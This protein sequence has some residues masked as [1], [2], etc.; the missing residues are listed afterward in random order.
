MG[1]AITVTFQ[2][3]KILWFCVR[4]MKRIWIYQ[5]GSDYPYPIKTIK[6]ES[7]SLATIAKLEMPLKHTI[8]GNT[9]NSLSAVFTKRMKRS[10]WEA[11]PTTS[12]RGTNSY[13]WNSEYTKPIRLPRAR[14]VS[15]CRK[16]EYTEPIGTAGPR[17]S[18]YCWKTQ[19][20]HQT[21]RN[22][23]GNSF[24]CWKTWIH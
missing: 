6:F 4:W 8:Q 11:K 21:Y 15:Y 1:E 5:W 2:E 14:R 3:S 13:C 12:R 24:Y 16:A 10:W 22:R 19:I 7:Q 20:L 9:T 18:T 17:G 23:S